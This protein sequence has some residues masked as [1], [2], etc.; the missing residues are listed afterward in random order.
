MTCRDDFPSKIR[1]ALAL[2]AGYRCSFPGC[3]RIT[4]G[5]SAES[6]E[7]V[8]SI[9]V[10]AH[11]C[12]AAPGGKRYDP[13]MTSDQRKDIS[14]A[15]WMCANHA[16]LIDRDDTTYTKEN[17]I[18]WKENHES[19][20]NSELTNGISLENG[21]K[22]CDLVALGPDVIAS[23]EKVSVD[24]EKW[25]YRIDHF[26]S[27]EIGDISRLSENFNKFSASDCYVLENIMGDGRLLKRKPTWYKDGDNYFVEVEVESRYPRK[28][29][30]DLGGDLAIDER[31]GLVVKNGDLAIVSGIDALPQKIKLNIWSS[32]GD[33]LYAPSYGSRFSELFP[34]YQDSVWIE[35]VFK[36]EL[37]RLASIPYFDEVTKKSYTP[38][39]C[40]DRVVSV[41]ILA[42]KPEKNMLPTQLK[43][44]IN[45]IGLWSLD[46]FFDTFADEPKVPQNPFFN[47]TNC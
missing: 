8:A 45:G 46:T 38:L 2:R 23:G 9:G 26:V 1:R 27:G 42:D 40:V 44:E 34:L 33:S 30:H 32:R 4:V 17:L 37:I 29:A 12:A 6:P 5:P 19:L 7:A 39:E 11:I 35:R 14:N 28:N 13:K 22:L 41:R 21:A 43:L 20:I 18:E 24:G 16:I 3:S 31:G 36:I 15:I 10:A 25:K 47:R